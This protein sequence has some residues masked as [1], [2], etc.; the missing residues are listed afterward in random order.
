MRYAVLWTLMLLTALCGAPAFA[1]GQAAH[2]TAHAS[3]LTL[4]PVYL[5][6]DGAIMT[7]TSGTLIDPY[8]PTKALLVA[9][10]NG[11]DISLLALPWIDWMLAH[12]DINGLFSRYCFKPGE[13]T[14]ENCA[15]ADA[16]DAMMAMWV[17]LLYR[18]APKS[19]MPDAWKLSIDKCLYQLDTLFNRETGVFN[20]SKSMQVGLL[21]DNIEIYSAFKRVERESVRIGDGKGSLTFRHRADYIRLGIMG[22]F[23]DNKNKRFI[24]STQDRREM[25]FYPDTVAQL[26]PMMHHFIIPQIPSYSVFYKQWMKHHRDEWFALIGNDYPWGLL[27]VYAADRGDEKTAHCWLQQAAPYRNSNVWNVLDETAFQIVGMKV[28]RKPFDIDQECLEDKAL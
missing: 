5:R 14:Y 26:I 18:M 13:T 11:M 1:R 12:Q 21:M 8:F 16:D 23:W 20:I 3:V 10:D 25:S 6:G 17:E 24:A 28:K 22:R 15:V 27:A 7:F 4:D 9:Q 19:G 2:K